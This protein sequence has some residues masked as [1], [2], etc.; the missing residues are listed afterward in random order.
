MP[1][2]V[3]RQRAEGDSPSTGAVSWPGTPILARFA[4]RVAIVTGAARGIGAATAAR[5]AADGARVLLADRLPEVAATAAAI[6][7]AALAID[8]T[9][10]GAG[11]GSPRPRSTPSA[12]S[13]SW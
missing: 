1:D 11:E 5:L 2:P 8:L 4:G 13:T 12:A 9:E 7:G 6:G 3:D 10:R